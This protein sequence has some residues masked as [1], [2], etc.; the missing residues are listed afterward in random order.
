MNALVERIIRS[1]EDVL[2]AR[3]DYLRSLAETSPAAFVKFGAAVPLTQHRR[4]APAS[5]WHLARLAA[6][7]V[8][9][10]GTCVQ[11]VVNQARADGV[12]A[13]T[14]R[15]A[16]DGGDLGA[17]DH[18]ALRYGEAVAARREV[19]GVVEA[20]RERFGEP[21]LVEMALAVATAQVFPVIKRGL[22]QD[23]ACALVEVEV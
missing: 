20:V 4:H 22:G 13:A 16:L 15:A 19:G 21:V 7:R 3:L 8:Q 6:T 17:D 2:G 18:L 1:Q 12:P 10:C 14:L 5:V 9:D 23:V 11:V